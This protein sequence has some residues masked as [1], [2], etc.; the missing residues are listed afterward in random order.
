L[1]GPPRSLVSTPRQRTTED[2]LKINK[3]R[4]ESMKVNAQ[5]KM[6]EKTIF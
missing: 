1:V 5:V 6:Y 2:K 3:E 4:F